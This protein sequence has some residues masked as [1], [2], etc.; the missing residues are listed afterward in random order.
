MNNL[1]LEPTVTAQWQALIKD[2]E[3][4]TH[5][6]LPEDLESYLVFLLVRFSTYADIAKTIV[7]VEFLNNLNLTGQKQ[8]DQLQELGDKCLLI[9]G[10]FPGRAMHR[11]VRISYFVRLGQVAYSRLA[12]L[13][14]HSLGHFYEKL[15]HDFVELMDVLQATRELTDSTSGLTLFQAEELWSDLHSQHAK[16]ILQRF[17]QGWI[18]HTNNIDKH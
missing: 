11:R 10:L 1:I 18:I 12:V 7:A 8:R 3:K 14:Q 2:A 5:I 13:Y 16:T 15:G 17:T 6:V 9:S 4:N